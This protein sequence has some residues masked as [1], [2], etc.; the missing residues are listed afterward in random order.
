MDF[1]SDC[2]KDLSFYLRELQSKP[3]IYGTDFLPHDA[4]AKT[5]AAGGRTFEQIIR[6]AGRRC[7]SF[8]G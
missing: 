5:L 8:P 2:L 1:I 4:Q 7:G 3:Y 6:A